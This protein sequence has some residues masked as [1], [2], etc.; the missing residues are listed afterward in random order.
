MA[1]KRASTLLEFAIAAAAAVVPVLLLVLRHRRC[2]APDRAVVGARAQRRSPR[3]RAPSRRAQDVR[4]RDRA[5][6]RR[7]RWVRPRRCCCSTAFRSAARAWDGSGGVL[8][9]VRR[10]LARPGATPPSPAQRLAAQLA[11]LDDALLRFSHRRQSSRERDGRLRLGA[12]VRRG[13]HR[14]AGSDRGGRIPGAQVHRPVRRHRERR[15]DARALE[16]PDARGAF[17][18][19]HRSRARD[20]AL[21]S[22]AVRRG[23]ARA[24]SRARIR[25]AGCRAASSSG[26]R[27]PPAA[28]RCLRT[29]SRPR[30][31]RTSA[32]ARGR[33]CTTPPTT[34]ARRRRRSG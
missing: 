2:R 26:T 12:L 6:E 5:P 22:R 8:D 20:G 14:D 16:R 28:C 9:R 27:R 25:G 19:R 33:R 7:C 15:D 4:A 24:R 21:A 31:R 34:I 11:D 30:A 32:S 29:S 3:E 1:E 10:A 18:A 23:R 17:V 13:R